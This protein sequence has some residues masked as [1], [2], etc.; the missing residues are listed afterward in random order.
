[1]IG[2]NKY[3][4]EILN[5]F[6][7]YVSSGVELCDL[8]QVHFDSG[9]VPDYTDIHSQQLYLLRY[10]YAYAFEY[11]R[12]YQMLERVVKL[13]NPLTVTSIGCGNMVDYWALAHSIGKKHKIFYRGVDFIDWN[14]K[15]PRR[16]QDQ[17][18]FFYQDAVEYF[19]S[20]SEM[21]AD[22]YIFPKSI[23]ELSTTAVSEICD[24]FYDKT[25]CQDTVS[26]LFS[27][28]TDDGS[29]ARDIA[30]TE[31][32][33]N[34]MIKCGFQTEDSPT[35]T[36]SFNKEYKD[37]KICDRDHEFRHPWRVVNFL[38]DLHIH[39]VNYAGDCCENDCESRLDRWPVLKC[40]K[41]KWQLFRF[42][43]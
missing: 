38:K 5:D 31:L 10:C 26:F 22:V 11:K 40:Q 25:F 41:M 8:K 15:F 21:L 18:E 1:M 19:K 6:E 17:L 4:D 2:I 32:F 7:Q 3:L 36:T 43:R 34:A 39:C 23:S 35:V 28:R 9:K 42:W 29:L 33:Y 12:M 24:T 37:L 27:L 16:F 14:Y 20:T 13:R 30:K